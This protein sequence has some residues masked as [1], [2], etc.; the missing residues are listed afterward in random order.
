MIVRIYLDSHLSIIH[1]YCIH[2]LNIYRVLQHLVQQQIKMIN[3]ST[4]V[5]IWLNRQTQQ[6]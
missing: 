5:A 2:K 1:D 4:T 6:H 3:L